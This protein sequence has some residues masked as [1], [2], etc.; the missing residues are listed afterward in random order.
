MNHEK[1]HK[2]A[3]FRF[4]VIGHLLSSPPGAGDLKEALR[5]LASKEW[6]DPVSGKMVKFSVSSIERWYYK[7]NKTNSPIISLGK[8]P[9]NDSGRYKVP[10][11]IQEALVKRF[12]EYPTWSYQLHYDNLLSE[13]KDKQAFERLPSYS[14]VKNFLKKSGFIK[15][16]KS[17][18]R[19]KNDKLLEGIMNS[20][21]ECRSFEN[22][23]SMGMW[24][25][26]F[27]HSSREIITAKGQ[28]VRPLALAILDDCSRIMCHI[29]WYLSETTEDLVHGFC[30]ALLKRGLPRKLLTDNG[31]AMMSKEFTEGLNRLSITHN[32]TLPYHPNQNG[33]QEIVWGQ[34]EGRLMEMLKNKKNITLKELNDITMAWCEMEY[35]K[36]HHSEIKTSPIDKF[37]NSTSVG[38][39]SLSPEELRMAFRRDEWRR[40]RTTDMTMSID[41]K[42]FEIPF[43]YRHIPQVKIRYATWDLSF[44]HIINEVSNQEVCRIYPLDKIANNSSIRKPTEDALSESKSTLTSVPTDELPPLI[45]QLI[46]DYKALGIPP[47]YIPKEDN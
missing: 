30:Q 44:I 15:W 8:K 46:N 40:I 45:T 26:D 16:S 25:L 14:T 12:K 18:H 10:M 38:R 43:Q 36:K 37:I 1:L 29:Q 2:W 28:V 32:T 39:P 34:V 20:S 22:E 17:R 5:S 42:R 4:S 11:Q 31:S 13:F 19:R 35:N 7:A 9:R 47:A 21:R 27:H 3:E 24:H 33:K 23:Y 41:G 6:K